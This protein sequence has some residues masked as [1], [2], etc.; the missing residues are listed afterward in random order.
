MAAAPLQLNQKLKIRVLP[1]GHCPA[2]WL[3]S[4]HVWDYF[5][6]CCEAL[7]QCCRAAAWVSLFQ[8]NQDGSRYFARDTQA[9]DKALCSTSDHEPDSGLCS[10][11]QP[12]KMHAVTILTESCFVENMVQLVGS[13]QNKVIERLSKCNATTQ[14]GTQPDTF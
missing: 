5:M 13:L 6:T 1:I 12:V 2:C 3:C 8:T 7:W 14:L 4:C 11:L 9:A 10:G